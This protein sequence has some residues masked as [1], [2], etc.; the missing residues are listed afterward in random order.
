MSRATWH[1]GRDSS[2]VKL[3]RVLIAFILALFYWLKPLK[4]EGGEKTGVP[5]ETP[6]DELQKIPY[7]KSPKSKPKPRLEPAL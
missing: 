3:D 6:D 4:G 2:A 7:T 1:D 5:G